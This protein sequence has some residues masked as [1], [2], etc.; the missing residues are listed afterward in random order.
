MDKSKSVTV[1]LLN[2]EF[3]VSCPANAEDQLSDA[4]HYLNQKMREIRKSGRV[5]GMERMA[6]MAALNI[7]YELAVLRQQQEAYLQ[8]VSTQIEHLQNKID[9]A[10]MDELLDLEESRDP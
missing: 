9:N 2:K 3:Q 7:A 6:V 1:T 4:A 8:S 5:I 10:L